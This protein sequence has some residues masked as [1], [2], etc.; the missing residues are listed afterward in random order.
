MLEQCFE[1]ARGG[2]PPVFGLRG[3]IIVEPAGPRAVFAR[4]HFRIGRDGLAEA[5]QQIGAAFD[6]DKPVADHALEAVSDLLV[7]EMHQ[8]LGIGAQRIG[9]IGRERARLEHAQGWRPRGLRSE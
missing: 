6:A 2:K 4:E 9:G 1:N 3:K 5:R 7:L 8:P